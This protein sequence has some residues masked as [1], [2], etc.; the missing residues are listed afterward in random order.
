MQAKKDKIMTIEADRLRALFTESGMTKYDLARKADIS[1]RTVYNALEGRG[2][3]QERIIGKL[4]TALQTSA[5][6]L[7]YGTGEK[8][9]VREPS[10]EYGSKVEQ[11]KI[12]LKD[13]IQKIA[14]E[15]DIS[16]ETVAKCFSEITQKSLNGELK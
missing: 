13:A 2:K 10:V 14:F 11:P 15:L 9:M 4:A 6:Y 12:S 5:E 16:V 1:Y 7:L 8:M 3:I